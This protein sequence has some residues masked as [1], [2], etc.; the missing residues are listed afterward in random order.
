MRHAR[1][2]VGVNRCLAM[3]TVL[4]S[5]PTQ[6]TA[7]AG[8]E[9]GGSRGGRRRMGRGSGMLL[10]TSSLGEPCL[11]P[12]AVFSPHFLQKVITCHQSK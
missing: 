2:A 6:E 8:R 12:A 5:G 9:V 1:G 11:Q 3:G 10:D 7:S 4:Q